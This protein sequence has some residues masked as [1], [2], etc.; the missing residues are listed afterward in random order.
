M[1][2]QIMA[3]CGCECKIKILSS[4]TYIVSLRLLSKQRGLALL[5]L[6]SKYHGQLFH[7]GRI[8]I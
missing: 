6:M 1:S 3:Q 4:F 2:K 5:I 8:L 7:V